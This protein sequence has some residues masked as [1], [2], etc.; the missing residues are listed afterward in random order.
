[1]RKVAGIACPV[2]LCKGKAGLAA[3]LTCLLA[4]EEWPASDHF[5]GQG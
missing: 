2:F 4:A 1:M 5:T 3:V